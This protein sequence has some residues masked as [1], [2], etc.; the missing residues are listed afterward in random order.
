M[1]RGFGGGLREE[2]TNDGLKAQ[3]AI[4]YQ[5]KYPAAF[6]RNRPTE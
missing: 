5:E 1:T 4:M 6:V 2:R 3:N